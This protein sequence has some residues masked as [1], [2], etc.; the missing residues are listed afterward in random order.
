M[1]YFQKIDLHHCHYIH[2]DQFRASI[3]W[4][5]E[6]SEVLP[7]SIPDMNCD[8]NACIRILCRNSMRLGQ[9]TEEARRQEAIK[10]SR[11]HV[12]TSD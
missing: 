10:Y 3:A 9:L 2:G 4:K 7:V 5:S 11:K 1:K 12:I 6:V 8:L